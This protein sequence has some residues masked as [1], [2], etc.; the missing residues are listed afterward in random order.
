[1]IRRE[2]LSV[3]EKLIRTM[4]DKIDKTL[5]HVPGWINGQTIIPVVRSDPRMIRRAQIPSTLRDMDLDWYSELGI[6][7]AD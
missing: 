1:M 2:A 5:S 6:R 3:I 4:E 7:L